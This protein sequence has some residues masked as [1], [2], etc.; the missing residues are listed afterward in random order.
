MSHRTE[1]G[2]IEAETEIMARY[3]EDIG[4]LK[5]TR[6]RVA[7]LREY[8]TFL[9]CTRARRSLNNIFTNVR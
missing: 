9:E 1:S 2:F 4:N 3:V 7:K 6:Q 5:D 8:M